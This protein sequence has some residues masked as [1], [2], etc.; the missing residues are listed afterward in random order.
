[1]HYNF[2]INARYDR[3][4]KMEKKRDVALNTGVEILILYYICE[5]QILR[6]N[7]ILRY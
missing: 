5:F 7:I 6:I 1:M 2:E 4:M 3:E